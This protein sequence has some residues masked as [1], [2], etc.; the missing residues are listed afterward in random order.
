MK[1][2]DYFFAAACGVL[3]YLIV[4]PT[5]EIK[6]DTSCPAKAGKRLMYTEYSRQGMRCVYSEEK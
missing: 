5:G 3:I 1:F 2:F 4:M 6:F